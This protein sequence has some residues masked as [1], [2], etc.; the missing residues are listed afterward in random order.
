MAN[1]P[2]VRVKTF[3]ISDTQEFRNDVDTFLTNLLTKNPEAKITY[4]ADG[5]V[6]TII[7]TY[8]LAN[9]QV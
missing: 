9:D 3:T 1:I 6:L 4:I 5:G 8:P 7:A 2:K